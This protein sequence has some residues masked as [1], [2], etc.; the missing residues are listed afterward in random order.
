M[1]K[2]KRGDKIRVTVDGWRSGNHN[3]QAGDVYV[4]NDVSSEGVHTNLFYFTFDEIELVPVAEATG[5]D[6]P[7]DAP[8]FKVGDRV[9]LKRDAGYIGTVKGR[10]S[11]EYRNE[12]A[13]T[14][15]MDW[16][17]N[18]ETTTTW[19][20]SE[21]EPV[22]VAPQQQLTIQ[23][24][25][26][27]LTRDGRKVGP[28][29]LSGDTDYPWWVGESKYTDSGEWIDGWDDDNDLVAEAEPQTTTEI[30]DELEEWIAKQ[31]AARDNGSTSGFTVPLCAYED[32]F[33]ICGHRDPSRKDSDGDIVQ[34]SVSE[35][36]AALADSLKVARKVGKTIKV[37][38]HVVL[39]APA[40]IAGFDKRNANIV[41]DTGG[42]FA[43]PI[44]ALAAA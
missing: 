43:L 7:K 33:D 4:V 13:Y 16:Y 31:D 14:V 11:D 17:G 20:E 38:D 25:K 2:F 41:L 35:L 26:F 18:P 27:Y 3:A 29:T 42:S 8:K 6:E 5:T 9:R 36:T 40:R 23:A 21:L 37:G 44:A 19:Y 32:D 30:L 1:G 15:N 28:A 10:S 12:P 24:G 22:A 39:T 34:L